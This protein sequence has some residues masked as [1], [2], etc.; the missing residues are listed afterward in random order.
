M[1]T[2]MHRRM[3]EGDTITVVAYGDSISEVGRTPGFFGGASSA[4]FNWAQQLQGL[5]RSAY[6]ANTM[7]VK[8]FGI[9]GQNSYEGLGR[10]D[11]LAALEP[12]VVIIAFGAN[13]AKFHLLDPAATYLA[14]KTL[15][16]NARYMYQVDV[17]VVIS[18]LDNP[19][20][21]LMQHVDDTRA[22]IRAAATETN[23]PVIDIHRAMLDATEQGVRWAE[24]HN[25]AADCHPN[26]R[27]HAVWAETAFAALQRELT[28][29]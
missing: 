11:A 26:D 13:D 14:Q 15:V 7:V 25:G 9:G 24:Y 2:R 5:L 20:A 22:A 19:R 12:D 10:L 18:P 23:A 28:I 29:I 17:L 1:L 27:G 21:S 16:E 6:P 4:A 8:N 3:A